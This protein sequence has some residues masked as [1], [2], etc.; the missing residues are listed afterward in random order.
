MTLILC[1]ISQSSSQF[2]SN[3][4]NANRVLVGYSSY[5]SRESYYADYVSYILNQGKD[6]QESRNDKFDL[7]TFSDVFPDDCWKGRYC[8]L[9][10]A[11]EQLK[12]MMPLDKNKAFSS[13]LETDYW[14]FGLIYQIVFN[15]KT[16][17]KD[18]TIVKNRGGRTLN[19]TLQDKLNSVIKS[20]RS[21]N[22]VNRLCNIR[23]RLKVSCGIYKD[24]VQ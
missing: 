15:G 5:G 9:R 13:W 12:D 17:K 22:N 20:K 16:L 1:A 10:N 4:E 14:L 2:K 8:I 21:K 7:F 23:E 3:G 19:I 24:Y 11:V 18:L 6:E